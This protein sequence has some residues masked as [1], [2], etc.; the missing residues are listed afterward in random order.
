MT[1][2][3]Q[4]P[5]I[6]ISGPMSNKP[7]YNLRAFCDAHVAL[8]ASG[9]GIIYNPAICWLQEPEQISITKN[10]GDYMRECLHELSRTD[11]NGN[12]FYDIVAQLDEW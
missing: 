3:T 10:H 12:A 2:R 8:K 11:E 6:F 1:H 7:D 5:N 4:H 9:A